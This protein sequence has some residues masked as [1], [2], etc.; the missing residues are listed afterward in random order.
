MMMS[1]PVDINLWMSCAGDDFSEETKSNG[2]GWAESEFASGWE[3]RNSEKIEWICAANSLGS[4]K[5]EYQIK[6]LN[7]AQTVL[8]L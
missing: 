1:A 6:I 8:D 2:D 5:K 3:E 7:L 4:N